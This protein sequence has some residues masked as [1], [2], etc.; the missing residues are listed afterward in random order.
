MP[1]T[2]RSGNA[3]LDWQMAEEGTKRLSDADML[4]R[5]GKVRPAVWPDGYVPL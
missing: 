4:E 1:H 5:I 3:T 2:E